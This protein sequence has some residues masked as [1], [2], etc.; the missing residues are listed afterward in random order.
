[1]DVLSILKKAREDVVDW[2]VWRDADR[3]DA[4][5]AVFTKIKLTYVVTGRDLS[6]QQ[7]KRAVELSMEKY[8]SVTKMLESSVAIE[9][10]TEIIAF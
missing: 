9:Y 4:V 1:M 8:C 6:E 5:P 2:E 3:A 7:V 10:A